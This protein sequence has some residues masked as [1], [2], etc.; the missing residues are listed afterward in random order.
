MK[1][2]IKLKRSM[3]ATEISFRPDDVIM[4]ETHFIQEYDAGDKTLVPEQTRI[5][6]DKNKGY[7]YAWITVSGK[8]EA[9]VNQIN[10][11]ISD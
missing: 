6:F 4:V 8:R 9:I 5:Y 11:A 7:P 3:D 10:N 2:L 1:R